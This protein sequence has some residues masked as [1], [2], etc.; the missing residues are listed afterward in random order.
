MDLFVYVESKKFKER[1][2]RRAQMTME[3]MVGR[4]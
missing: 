3:C 1:T 2:L 4:N